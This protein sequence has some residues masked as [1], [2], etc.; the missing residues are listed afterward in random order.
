MKNIK[1]FE[2]FIDNED[3]DGGMIDLGN[4]ER[5]KKS[6]DK[7][8]KFEIWGAYGSDDQEAP[9]RKNGNY[10]LCIV[11]EDNYMEGHLVRS[12]RE[13]NRLV[14]TTELKDYILNNS[15]YRHRIN[16]DEDLS[17]E[18]PYFGYRIT[19]FI[20][21]PNIYDDDWEMDDI[22]IKK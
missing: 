13:L 9:K 15:I 14:G 1:L 11:I 18:W 16:N 10:A 20:Y 5:E 21:V 12:T 6:N 4:K 19:T 3:F 7:T 17:H 8:K 22:N 2:E